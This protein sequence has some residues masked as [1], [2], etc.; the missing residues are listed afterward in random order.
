MEL[1]MEP[2]LLKTKYAITGRLA[3]YSAVAEAPRFR[4]ISRVRQ[5][6]YFTRQPH[7]GATEG[8]LSPVIGMLSETHDAARQSCTI[9]PV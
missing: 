3:Q 2:G 8:Q 6:Y 4:A 7:T 1:M 9:P 5:H